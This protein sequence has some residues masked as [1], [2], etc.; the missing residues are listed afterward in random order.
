MERGFPPSHRSG[1]GLVEV[2]EEILHTYAHGCYGTASKSL[3]GSTFWIRKT[4]RETGGILSVRLHAFA[5][6]TP[7]LPPDFSYDHESMPA[8][9]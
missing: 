6:R 3:F 7:S 4:Q 2:R 1:G 8:V 5:I 9:T